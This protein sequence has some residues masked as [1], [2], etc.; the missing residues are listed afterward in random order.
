M[1]LNFSKPKCILGDA[2]KS[3]I[4]STHWSMQ[5]GFFPDLH[6][7]IE[8]TIPEERFRRLTTQSLFI[9]QICE[10][11]RGLTPWKLKPRHLAREHTKTIL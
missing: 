11:V 1:V 6:F 10:A 2:G 8:L 5:T 3:R 9:G 4:V 7:V